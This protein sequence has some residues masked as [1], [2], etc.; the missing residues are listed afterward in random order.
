MLFVI[1]FILRMME[2][3]KDD[4][5]NFSIPVSASSYSSLLDAI[6]KAD[7]S[8][9]N[10][11]LHELT[12]EKK[13]DLIT[14]IKSGLNLLCRATDGATLAVLLNSLPQEIRLQALMESQNFPKYS[15]EDNSVF[16]NHSV[17]IRNCLFLRSGITSFLQY[18][19][20]TLDQA[21]ASKLLHH[22]N[23]LLFGCMFMELKSAESYSEADKVRL[24]DILPKMREI[25]SFL[26]PEEMTALLASPTDTY[27][28]MIS[29]KNVPIFHTI[30][31]YKW[32]KVSNSVF[33]ATMGS[34]TT[35]VSRLRALNIADSLG[36]STFSKIISILHFHYDGYREWD[37]TSSR[38]L[39]QPALAFTKT[40]L[41]FVYA[42]IEDEVL[43]K[44]LTAR[45]HFGEPALHRINSIKI[46]RATLEKYKHTEDRF[47]LLQKQDHTGSTVLHKLYIESFYN[48]HQ[49]RVDN[50]NDLTSILESIGTN[51]LQQ[52]L[53][54][55]NHS[56]QTLLGK[57]FSNEKETEIAMNAV[58][59][60][61]RL[62]MLMGHMSDILHLVPILKSLKLDERL[63]MMRHADT[64]GHTLLHAHVYVHTC[65]YPNGL[66]QVLELLPNESASSLLLKTD[67]EGNTPLHLCSNFNAIGELLNAWLTERQASRLLEMRNLEGNTLLH[68]MEPTDIVAVLRIFTFQNP[69]SFLCLQNE[70]RETVFHRAIRL[71]GRD[72][73][74]KMHAQHLKSVIEILST[75]ATEMR[76][77]VISLADEEGDTAFQEM[78]YGLP[79]DIIALLTCFGED[80]HR[81]L[82]LPDYN[83]DTSIHHIVRNH[84][85]HTL[86]R[87]MK[88]ISRSHSLDLLSCQN[89]TGSTPLHLAVATKT[90][91]MI[92]SFI[93]E[94]LTIEEAHELV[95]LRDQ[96]GYQAIEY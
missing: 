69:H 54:I 80:K 66:R 77:Q 49:K 1:F 72:Q 17:G 29:E 58:P 93:M 64:D 16:I 65:Y 95:K 20:N 30:F 15:N 91:P 18:I 56:G 36:E 70:K 82:M 57:L 14:N 44:L 8:T 2:T 25:F 47:T 89:R 42:E 32:I 74:R 79:D 11:L 5:G 4:F 78:H 92:V 86:C 75:I 40:C 43:M 21:D 87:V 88:E 13:Y 7:H 50:S 46:L 62:A 52:L 61:R 34:L 90:A 59:S 35:S 39:N 96:R 71:Y 67:L 10:T 24:E 22:K 37:N 63:D 68:L 81:L 6:D 45:N 28:Y 27:M 19:I 26:T 23:G 9:I 53:T 12:D 33:H 85:F 55:K 76:Y 38:L 48:S 83:G 41:G 31:T 84:H 51:E 94:Q 60:D 73:N 3:C